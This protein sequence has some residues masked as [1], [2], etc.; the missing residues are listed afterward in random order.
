M[1]LLPLAAALAFTLVPTPSYRAGVRGSARVATGAPI[2]TG[3]A[4]FLLEGACPNP[5]GVERRSRSNCPGRSTP[6]S[7]P[8]TRP[9]G[10]SGPCWTVLRPAGPES[11]IWDGRDAS[12]HRVGSGVH[13]VR[14][15]LAGFRG[16]RRILMLR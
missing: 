3:P 7:L 12:G 1:R 9:H 10:A 13:F 2:A 15:D 6:S 8:M 5:R 11:E 16:A 4:V 14:M